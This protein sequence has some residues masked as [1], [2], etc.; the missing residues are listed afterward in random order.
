MSGGLASPSL[1]V[2]YLVS[3]DLLLKAIVSRGFNDPAIVK[4]SDAPAFGY[5]APQ[6]L[7]PEKI[8]SYQAGVEANVSELLRAKLI[9]FYHV[10]D[11]ILIDKV[12]DPESRTTENGGSGKT[13]G[14]EFEIAT[15]SFNGFVF[16]SGA[17]Y[18]NRKAIDVNDPQY[19]DVSDIY[20]VNAALTYDAKKGLRGTMQAH[21]L[22]WDMQEFRKAESRGVV[23]DLS[24]AKKLLDTGKLALDL[25]GS[26]HNI[27]DAHSYNDQLQQNPGQWFEAGARCTF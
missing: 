21:Y 2:T 9:L 19:S 17:S 25:F 8:W 18:E 4:Y 5:F 14:G 15:N 7:K 27:F 22:W 16:K 13:V 20:G 1:G 24:I 11:D 3:R 10:I 23:V 6:E 12:T 26:A